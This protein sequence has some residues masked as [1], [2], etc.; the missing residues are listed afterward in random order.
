[1]ITILA[2]TAFLAGVSAQ[3]REAYTVCLSNAFV[4]AKI[5]KVPVDDFKAYA[6]KTCAAAEDELRKTLAAFNVKN[7]MGKKTATEDAQVQIDDY[8]FT[9][10][11]NYRYA[12][13]PPKPAQ[14]A[15]SPS[16]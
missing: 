8:V 7:G 5:S 15:I 2:A 13:Q 14:A 4:N 11:E 1:M 16:K 6:H 9:A 10:E 3:P 12:L